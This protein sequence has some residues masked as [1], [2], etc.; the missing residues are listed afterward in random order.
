MRGDKP[1]TSRPLPAP[2]LSPLPRPALPPPP[3]PGSSAS[4]GA[5][6]LP[7]CWE[8]DPGQPRLPRAPR[9]RTP[10]T[11]RAPEPGA[12]GPPR[13]HSPRL[14]SLWRPGSAP[15]RTAAASGNG[16]RGR[17]AEGAGPHRAAGRGSDCTGAGP[18]RGGVGGADGM[19]TRRPSCGRTRLPEARQRDRLQEAEAAP[20][21][22]P[23]RPRVQREH[24]KEDGAAFLSGFQKPPSAPRCPALLFS[25]GGTTAP[26]SCDYL[27]A[28]RPPGAGRREGK[29]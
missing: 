1:L 2:P 18:V 19:G 5:P 23:L 9:R 11:W 6:R 13:P 25:Q 28:P 14:D 26:V 24:W 22:P 7:L 16:G 4:P 3:T 10:T 21:P 8:S 12:S 29:A 15:S 17:Q 27:T 20:E